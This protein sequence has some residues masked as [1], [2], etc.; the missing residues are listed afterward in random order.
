MED[1]I[2][3]DHFMQKFVSNIG[4]ILED[5]NSNS[6]FIDHMN[7]K[8]DELQLENTEDLNTLL[9]KVCVLFN[10]PGVRCDENISNSLNVGLDHINV[11]IKI[12][13]GEEMTYSGKDFLYFMFDKMK[14]PTN[15]DK[16]AIVSITPKMDNIL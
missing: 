7:S 10:F 3:N 9:N 4:Q 12:E 6:Y 2:I 1:I 14:S 13:T 16:I 5:S 15:S 11:V 8:I